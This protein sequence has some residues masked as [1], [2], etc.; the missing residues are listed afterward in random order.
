MFLN[1]L[2][3]DTTKSAKLTLQ[4]QNQFARAGPYNPNRYKDYYVPRTL[5]KNE[6][7]VEFV[8]SQHSVPTSPIRNQ[9]HI[10]PVRESGPL[11]AYDGTYTMEDVRGIFHNTTAGRDLCYCQMDPEE[12]M[13]R[14]PGITRK[15]SEWITKLG[16]SPQEQ[17]DFAYIAYNI[18]LDVFYF[19][20]QMFVARQ[21]VTN[22]K[23]EKV[24]VLWNAQAYEDIALLN[25][26][27]A[28]VL[29][30]VDYH[31]EIFLWADPPIKPNND[32]D[33]NVPCT[34]FEYEQEWWMESN[35]QEDQMNLP[36]DERPYPTP[37]NPHCRKELWR[38][39][40]ALQE[41]E[42]MTSESWYPKD[43]QFN[44]YNQPEYQKPKSTTKTN[45]DIRI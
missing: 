30:S 16:L 5:P 36:E 6:E 35:F 23:G 21:V 18:G 12:I 20:N 42:L 28:P 37:R 4:L 29:E 22:S 15:E 13:R 11:P 39:Q 34:W 17:V 45:D 32:F 43:T 44:I 27:F 31:W 25:V 8:Q 3:K 1:K 26:G 41:E 14:V 24:E 33:L 38:S 40:D 19:S 10:N 9:R 7:I 2:L